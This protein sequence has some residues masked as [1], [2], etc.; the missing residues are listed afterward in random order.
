[1]LMCE[2]H[3]MKVPAAAINQEQTFLYITCYLHKAAEMEI[4]EYITTAHFDPHR[5]YACV[6][7]T[8]HRHTYTITL[9]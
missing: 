5:D 8:A 2:A 6:K 3:V 1:M 7:A 9:C 4:L